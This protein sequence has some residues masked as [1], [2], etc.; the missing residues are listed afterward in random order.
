MSPVLNHPSMTN[1]SRVA[2][3]RL[4]YPAKTLGPLRCSSPVSSMRTEMPGSGKPDAAR[5]PLPR[6]GIR[7]VHQRFRHAVALENRVAEVFAELFQHLRR[8]RRGAGDK[9]PHPLADLARGLDAAFRAAART[10]S[11]RRRTASAG[12]REMSPRRCDDRSV[13]AA[14]CGTRRSASNADR[15]PA[16]AHETAAAPA[17]SGRDP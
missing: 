16:R 4:Q 2:S 8:Q 12:N 1:A 17:G 6:V 14:A 7:D 13:R 11:A 15:C 3:S 5:P 10:W 9:Q